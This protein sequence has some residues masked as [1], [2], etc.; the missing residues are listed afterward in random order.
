MYNGITFK[1]FLSG[2]NAVEGIL[3]TR[4]QGVL[5]AGLYEWQYGIKEVDGFYWF[6]GAGAHAG[7]FS[8]TLHPWYSV[9]DGPD[10]FVLGVDGII[11]LEYV[12]KEFPLDIAIDYKPSFNVIGNQ[13]L[14]GDEFA[15][16]FRYYW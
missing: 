11:G 12:V 3:T 2:S 1:H 7:Y 6:A 5:I 13:R 4:W 14:N 15:I 9:A 10:S 8:G 16:S